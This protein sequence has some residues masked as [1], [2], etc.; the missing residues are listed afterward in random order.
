M[1]AAQEVAEGALLLQVRIHGGSAQPQLQSHSGS[2]TSVKAESQTR[3]WCCSPRDHHF[4]LLL[5]LLQVPEKLMLS[6]NTAL[7]SKHCGKLVRAAELSEWQVR[8]CSSLQQGGY[9][10]VRACTPAHPG[11]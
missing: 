6:A 7:S 5:I 4:P 11:V 8:V 9:E 3:V 2:S 1:L 10:A